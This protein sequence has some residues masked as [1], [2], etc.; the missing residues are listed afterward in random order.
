VRFAVLGPIELWVE[1]RLVPLG[2]PKQRALLAFLLLHANQAVSRD[3]LIDALWGESPPPSASESLDAYVYRLRKL[4]GHD[5]LVRRGSGYVL[6]VEAGELDADRF[7]L[8]VTGA[9]VAADAGDSRGAAKMLTEALGLWRG[10]ALADVLYEPFASGP[11][12]QLE[13][14]RLTALESRVEAELD[15]AGGA[16]LVPEL[17]QLVA[18][19]PLRERLVAALMLALYRAG[20][21]A[22]ALAVFQAARGQIVDELGLEPGPQ[23]RELE[24][25]ILRHDPALAAPRLTVH[26]RGPR[27]RALQF[28][29]VALILGAALTAGMVLRAG[30][31]HAGHTAL[32]GA[33]G[34]VAVDTGSGKLVAATRLSGTPEA[35]ANGAG[36]VWAADPGAG[37]VTQIDPGTGAAVDQVLVG[38]EPGSVVSGGGAIWAAS[39]VAATVT[40]ID[41]AT[42]SVTQTITLPGA[43]PA[44]IAYGAGRLWVADSAA[45]AVF[46]I[47]P[48]S[49][50][51][52]R[53]LPL[54]L[55][56]SAVT[57][58]GGALWVAGY[59]NATVERLDPASGR[60]TGRVHV[61]GG[62]A[63]LAVEAGALWVA[64]SLDA[65]VSRVDLATLK[66][67]ATIPVG[68]GPAA[69]AAS[70]GSLWVANQYSGTV[71]RID[72]Q[73]DQV[74]ASVAVG[75]APTSLTIDGGRMWAGVA[76]NGQ[77]HR[78][79]TLVIVTPAGLLAAP[80]MS[81][82]S[83]DPAFYN[84][85]NNPQFTGLAYDGL[86]NFQQSPG[87]AG[88]RL[89]PDLALAIPASAD[90]GAAYT[91]R[92]RPGIRYSDG[93]PLRASDFRRAF[94]RLFRV[95]SPGTS[96]YT[97]IT[98][99]AACAQHPASCDL[100]R[101]IVTDDATRTVTFHLTAPDPQ[102]LFNLT[103]QGFAAPIPPGTPDHETGSR[104]VP[105]TG[106]YKIV[107]VGNTE[108]RFTR[109][110]FFREWS[111]AAQP[112]GNPGAIV[113]R[114]V[115]TPQ[116]AVAAIEHGQADWM[117]GLI[118]KAEYRQLRLQDPAQLHSSPQ[119]AVDFAHINTHRA[120]FNDVRVRQALDYAIDRGKIVQ[121]YGG[122]SF[123]TPTCQPVT[124]GLPGYR[125]YCP[126]TLHPRPDGAWSA[127]DLAR[128]RR[129]VHESGTLG[130]RVDIWG[131]SDN[132][133]IP[134]TVPAYFAAV[135]RSLG[136]RVHLHD[137]PTAAISNAM[138]R[139]FQLSIDGDWLAAYPDPSS[140][141]P[142]FF[143]CGGGNNGGYYCS[144][145]LD[146]QM[147]QASQFEL[148]DPAK[149]AATWTAIDHQ[150]TDNAVWVPTVN[151]REVDLVSKRLRNYEYNPVWGFLAD[152][153]WL[154]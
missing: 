137:V 67:R 35:V 19:Y 82:A 47:D 66:V 76:A 129:L 2:G 52:E 30:T 81:A 115:P 71:S 14:R 23:M 126:Y 53:T 102:F 3:R 120:P 146:R 1:G 15:C 22:D 118:P 97:G 135:L 83:V 122:P 44:A 106:P 75:G 148:D 124:P 21:Q 56:P 39:T 133:Y 9:R 29:A 32:A 11:A 55:Q 50:S 134:R 91:F 136:Y 16:A 36:S 99:A 87:A 31:A 86:V 98:G 153:A 128:A 27:A 145:P 43:N 100:S 20:R 60:V 90:G 117:F 144:P 92:L 96:L 138:R 154:G 59:N 114:S 123:A 110:P 28:A 63:A 33:N 94:E 121:L 54:D 57:L 147:Q 79:G 143:S 151:E 13:E 132:P 78:G 140:Y 84:F 149:A 45:R 69:L 112:A 89:V 103:V 58:V 116:A 93:Q 37:T 61:G 8:L 95:G 142:P 51:L 104:T 17:E 40:R 139:H 77:R 49:G 62:P 34:L 107:D 25:R 130:Q 105:G 109:N 5:R 10:P 125:R 74:R 127:P 73:H 111:H 42:E 64:N 38:G 68:S 131:E 4:V 85:A 6:S 48:A 41:P 119:F 152:Q 101:G 12:R 26:A 70:R 72:P 150:L 24:Q 113:W 88:L 65:T 108:V 80:P 141:I 18:D 46:A 7:G